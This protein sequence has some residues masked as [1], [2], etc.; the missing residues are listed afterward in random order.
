LNVASNAENSV[1]NP[2]IVYL[3]GAGPGDP[4]LITVRGIECLGKAQVVVFD[5]LVSPLLRRHARQALWIDVGKQPDHH[6]IPQAEINALLIEHARAGKTV[7]RLKGGDP[8]VFGRGGEEALAL[9]EAGIPFEVV[10]GVSSAIAVPAY[11]GIPVTQRGM[12]ASVAFITGHRSQDIDD[13]AAALDCAALSAGTRVFLMGVT[14]LPAIV[15]R[16]LESGC[17]P[18]TPAAVIQEGT[19][20]RQK[21]VEGT[22]ANIVERSAGIQ[23]PAI[24]IVGEVVRL[25]E[26]LR[27]FDLP[28]IRPL[29]GLRVLNTRPQE[30]LGRDD[31]DER[32]SNL[33]AEVL[34]LPATRIVPPPDPAGLE[35]AIRALAQAVAGEPAYDWIVFT[36][37]NA[38]QYFFERLLALGYDAR[39][40]SGVK[41]GA[42]GKAT[43]A[44]LADYHLIADFV[45]SRFTGLDWAAEVGDL[46]GQRVLLP[47]S[48]IAPPDLVQA[49]QAKGAQVE[50]VIAY[51]VA[52][53]EPDSQALQALI[54]GQIDVIALFS[55]SAVRGLLSMLEAAIGK[56]PALDLLNRLTVACVGPTTARA[57]QEAGLQVGLVARQHTVEGLVESLI[58]WRA[59]S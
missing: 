25:R 56:E 38:V 40:L 55:P 36:S 47:R 43:A 39:R 8:F 18:D 49:L 17:S 42:V 35:W 22:L 58:E 37:A 26:H 59:P 28:R 5:R 24:T 12:T 34:N 32:L 23:P 53:A 9:V 31:L 41:L 50:T 21:V 46:S 3:V 52:P 16:M 30:S 6:P 15:Q 4:G 14:N 54:D 44:A 1:N 2:G 20:S 7:V 27:W 10:P 19:T 57:A 13:I 29:L 11:A 48:E 45:P 33:G 51:S